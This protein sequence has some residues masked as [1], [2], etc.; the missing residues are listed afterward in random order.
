MRI[1]GFLHPPISRTSQGKTLLVSN[2]YSCI[3][4][5]ISLLASQC[6]NLHPRHLTLLKPRSNHFNTPSQTIPPHHHP[7]TQSTGHT[8]EVLAQICKYE[9]KSKHF[10]DLMLYEDADAAMLR[11]FECFMESAPQTILQIYILSLKFFA[12]PNEPNESHALSRCVFHCRL[13]GFGSS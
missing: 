3:I 4:F 8:P 5:F 10:Y 13:Y 12:C 9:C 7:A 2:L 1:T 6:F 11:L